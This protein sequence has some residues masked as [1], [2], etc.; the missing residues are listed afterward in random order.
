MGEKTV[1]GDLLPGLDHDLQ[2]YRKEFTLSNGSTSAS[3]TITFDREFSQPPYVATPGVRVTSAKGSAS[4]VTAVEVTPV[5]TTSADV[6]AYVDADPAE[7]IT[8]EVDLMAAEAP[9]IAEAKR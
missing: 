2:V 9:N 3:T 6:Y 7:D 5:S 4:Y 8:I 1:K